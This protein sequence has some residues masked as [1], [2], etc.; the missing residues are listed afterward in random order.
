MQF[1]ASDEVIDRTKPIPEAAS[2]YLPNVTAFALPFTITVVFLQPYRL[3]VWLSSTFSTVSADSF[4]WYSC[5]SNQDTMFTVHAQSGTLTMI[6][7]LPSSANFAGFLPASACGLVGLTGRLTAAASY[8]YVRPCSS[9]CRT[10]IYLQV[11]SSS[12][13]CHRLLA[14]G[15][16]VSSGSCRPSASPL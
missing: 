15:S 11:P 10:C 14:Q 8:A 4:S 6:H 7:L 13:L 2:S 16:C 1:T 9:K 5:R 3:T 12:E